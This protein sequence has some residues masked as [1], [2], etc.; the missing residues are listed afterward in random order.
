MRAVAAG[1]QHLLGVRVLLVEDHEDTRDIY[2]HILGAE[3]AHVIA[4]ASARDAA[5]LLDN[6]DVVVTDV[7]LP[8]EDGIWL[9][10]QARERAAHVPVIGVSGWV[11]AQDARLAQAAFDV[12]FLKPLDPWRLCEEVAAVLHSRLPH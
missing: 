3:G 4:A 12:L 2:A 1:S 11:A 5:S 10:A 7:G 6:A 9:L 8:G